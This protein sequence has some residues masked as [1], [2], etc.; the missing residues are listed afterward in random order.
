MK[1]RESQLGFSYVKKRENDTC[2]THSCRHKYDSLLPTSLGLPPLLSAIPCRVIAMH[3]QAED[4]FL[5]SVIII[6]VSKFLRTLKIRSV[7]FH[8]ECTLLVLRIF[9]K[10]VEYFIRMFLVACYENT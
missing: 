5:P 9:V 10:L 2:K 4:S 1:D 3:I 7:H 6:R 8:I